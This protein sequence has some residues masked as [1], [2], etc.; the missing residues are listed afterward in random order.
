MCPGNDPR[1]SQRICSASARQ[2]KG[3]ISDCKGKL[4]GRVN[5]PVAGLS[6][7]KKM[8]AMSL[9]FVE[10]KAPDVPVIHDE[11][12]DGRITGGAG[13]DGEKVP[14]LALVLSSAWFRQLKLQKK[15]VPGRGRAVLKPDAESK[16]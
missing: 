16:K 1:A 8:V 14:H 9:V 2:I 15:V 4:Q 7:E 5:V 6:V 12:I 10:V 3:R 13:R 11:K